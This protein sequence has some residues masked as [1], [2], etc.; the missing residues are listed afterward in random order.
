MMDVLP[1][2]R[3]GMT[4]KDGIIDKNVILPGGKH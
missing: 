1:V 2:S 3:C 4:G